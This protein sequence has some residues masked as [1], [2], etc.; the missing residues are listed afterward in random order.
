[1]WMPLSFG[2]RSSSL[3]FSAIADAGSWSKW[4]LIEWT[5]MLMI[6]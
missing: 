6:S 5:I 2:L 4:E 1:M 3:I